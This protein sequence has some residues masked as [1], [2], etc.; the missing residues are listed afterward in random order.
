MAL[1]NRDLHAR[2]DDDVCSCC[3]DLPRGGCNRD[4]PRLSVRPCLSMSHVTCS[5][6]SKVEELRS[7]GRVMLRQE[8][9]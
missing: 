1:R 6:S 2:N 3:A 7:E 4:V 5:P 9:C 8:M